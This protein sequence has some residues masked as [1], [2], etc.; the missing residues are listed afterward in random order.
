MT[1][2][3]TRH[4]F[5]IDKQDY[6]NKKKSGHFNGFFGD[7]ALSQIACNPEKFLPLLKLVG[8]AWGWDHKTMNTD[9]NKLTERLSDPQSKLFYLLDKNRT[10]GYSL[11]TKPSQ[12]VYDNFNY[13]PNDCVIEIENLG[14]F[15]GQE[16]QG[17]GGKYF[18]LMFD[19]LF[20][21]YEHVYWSMSSTNYQGLYNYYKNKLGMTYLG[22]DYIDDFRPDYLREATQKQ[23]A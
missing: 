16:G 10:V 4:H 9:M 23:A 3:I 7:L 14:L 15:P 13:A 18:E 11:V 8:G 17:R 22:M 19:M 6:L 5:I 2:K 12:C 20:Q 1:D 21:S